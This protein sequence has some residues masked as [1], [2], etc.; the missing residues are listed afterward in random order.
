MDCTLLAAEIWD[1]AAVRPAGGSS[2]RSTPSGIRRCALG[3]CRADD[4][5]LVVARTHATVGKNAA[6]A[7]PFEGLLIDLLGIGLKHQALARTPTARVHR[8]VI[9]QGEF[10]LVV[11]GI[12][13]RAQMDVGLGA[14]GGAEGLAQILRVGT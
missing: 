10:V 9:A 7:D 2:R 1:R 11:A 5:F 8:Q 6:V 3:L 12:A 13:I 4:G 14:P